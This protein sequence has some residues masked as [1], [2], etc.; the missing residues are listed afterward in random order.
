MR[1]IKMCG[2]FMVVLF[3]L[4]LIQAGVSNT[5]GSPIVTT[6]T[7]PPAETSPSPIIQDIPSEDSSEIS[8]FAIVLIITGP[9]V[10]IL[11]AFYLFKKKKLRK[12]F[13]E[14]DAQ[15]KDIPQ[16]KLWN[17]AKVIN[18]IKKMPV[19][20][21][22]IVDEA[23]PEK[24]NPEEQLIRSATKKVLSEGNKLKDTDEAEKARIAIEKILEEANLRDKT[25]FDDPTREEGSVT[26]Y[27]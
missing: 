2:L 21:T 1:T 12:K 18:Q 24:I 8:T 26:T 16:E 11:I 13:Q 17:N 4:C 15:P 27:R 19:G 14:F 22:V 9:I 7:T 10:I 20:S 23:K 3:S 6:P 25:G 5:N